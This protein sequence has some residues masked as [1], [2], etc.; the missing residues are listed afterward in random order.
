MDF[1]IE[2][3]YYI[4]PSPPP[5]VCTVD[6]TPPTV[7][8]I[9]DIVRTIELGQSGVQVFFTEPTASD[10]SGQ[11]NLISRTAS[12]GDTFAVGVT[13]VTYVFVD[14]SGNQAAPCT[15]TVT[16]NTGTSHFANSSLAMK[17]NPLKTIWF[18]YNTH[19]P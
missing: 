8:C 5:L 19:F 18:C 17:F 7:S 2:C 3:F 4:P 6:T 1:N 13:T 14:G 16:V 11:V 10:V 15:F 9:N 12:P